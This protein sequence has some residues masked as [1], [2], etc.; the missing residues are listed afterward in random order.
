MNAVSSLR[1]LVRW[2]ENIK[3]STLSSGVPARD[4]TSLSTIA[5]AVS[6]D[7]VTATRSVPRTHGARACVGRIPSTTTAA[8]RRDGRH[9]GSRRRQR[10]VSDVPRKPWG[11]TAAPRKPTS[12]SCLR[13]CHSKAPKRKTMR[14]PCSLVP[15]QFSAHLSRSSGSWWRGLSFSPR[16]KSD[17]APSSA[18]PSAVVEG[19]LSKSFRSANGV[20]DAVDSKKRRSQL[21]PP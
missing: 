6:L 5:E 12:Y 16:P 9:I 10:V 20:D 7:A 15:Q 4:A 13:R 11:I 1:P 17:W 2:L 19:E 21:P 3:L 14:H 8:P 18:A